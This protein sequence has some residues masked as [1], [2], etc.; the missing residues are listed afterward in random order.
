MIWSLSAIVVKSG[1]STVLSALFVLTTSL[2][3]SPAVIP[4]RCPESG[5]WSGTG[6]TVKIHR[7]DTVSG[8][9]TTRFIE[10]NQLD[11]T[12]WRIDAPGE[13]A[14]VFDRNFWFTVASTGDGYRFDRLGLMDH[15]DSAE[16]TRLPELG[17]ILNASSRILDLN[18]TSFVQ[19]KGFEVIA[20]EPPREAQSDYRL[21]WN[22]T[23]QPGD[24]EFAAYGSVEWRVDDEFC[25]V[26]GYEYHFGKRPSEIG[27]PNVSVNVEYQPYSGRLLPVRL[28]RTERTLVTEYTRTEI[29]GCQQ[30]RPF[31]SPEAF[32]LARPNAPWQQ[33]LV[34]ACVFATSLV[35]AIAFR[36]FRNAGH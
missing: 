13:S 32:G 12:T 30:D 20:N 5:E 18:L 22:F 33:W 31:Y 10:F 27:T 23:P 16:E 35:V 2:F 3:E 8:K 15:P 34:W 19:R 26:T 9:A 21:L 6:V 29:R 1:A 17:G 14:S 36:F 7:R 11:I 4:D 25:R 24:R 28:V